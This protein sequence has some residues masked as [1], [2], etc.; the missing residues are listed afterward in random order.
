[1]LWWH[2]NL[3]NKPFKLSK[4]MKK[5]ITFLCLI[6]ALFVRFQGY[7]QVPT[8]IWDKT[9]GSSG[10][11]EATSIVRTSDGGFVIAGTSSSDISGDKTEAFGL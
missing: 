1:V 11:D 9:I 8:K 3:A 5:I 10:G 2:L 7:T 6:I 4:I